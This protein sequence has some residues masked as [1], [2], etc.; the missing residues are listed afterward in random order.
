MLLPLWSSYIVRV[1]AWR[2]ILAENGVLNWSLN[3]LG[4]PDATSRYT[5][6]AMWIVFAYVWLP[7]MIL[8]VFASLERIPDNFLEASRR[9][10]RA[11]AG[12]RCAA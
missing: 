2:V 5:R 1:Y 7:F 10:G 6:R 3:G 4:L 11:A 8:P 12:G 9:S